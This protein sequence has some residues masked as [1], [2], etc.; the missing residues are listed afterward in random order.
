MHRTYFFNFFC[1]GCF[2]ARL[3]SEDWSSD[4]HF[5][6]ALSQELERPRHTKTLFPSP[7]LIL[8]PRITPFFL[9]PLALTVACGQT[10]RC[11]TVA[12]CRGMGTSPPEEDL[13]ASTT[14]QPP[15]VYPMVSR[16]DSGFP[17]VA[18]PPKPRGP[19]ESVAVLPG[20]GEGLPPITHTRK[21]GSHGTAE[22][23]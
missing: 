20:G 12:L 22:V 17:C 19:T 9:L 15:S 6:K 21:T 1:S 23:A 18:R 3:L 5:T 11:A 2:E 4:C 14:V 7:P 10:I 13:R 8:H 16:G